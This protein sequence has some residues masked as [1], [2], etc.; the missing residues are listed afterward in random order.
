[1]D[2]NEK[3]EEESKFKSTA[4]SSEEADAEGGELDYNSVNRLLE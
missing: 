1:M 2:S 3:I 4:D